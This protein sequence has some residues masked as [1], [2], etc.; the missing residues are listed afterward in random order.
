MA[1][2]IRRSKEA[3]AAKEAASFSV[4]GLA[5]MIVAVGFVAAA[6]VLIGKAL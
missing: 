3:P 1:K 5:C 6:C 4:L 2:L